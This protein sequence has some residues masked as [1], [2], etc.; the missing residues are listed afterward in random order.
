MNNK[1]EIWIRFKRGFYK[2]NFYDF[3]D[4]FSSFFM[5]KKFGFV[6]VFA[7]LINRMKVKIREEKYFIAFSIELISKSCNVLKE[8]KY[9]RKK[10]QFKL[11]T[12]WK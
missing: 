9:L 11:C 1:W 7:D 5:M 4:N 3:H 10:F 12:L 2:K 6:E 8:C